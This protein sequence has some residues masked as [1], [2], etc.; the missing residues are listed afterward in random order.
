MK[1]P[2]INVHILIIK[3]DK[4]LLGLLT[5][6]CKYKGKQAYGIPGCDI[7][8]DEKIRGYSQEKY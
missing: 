8:L 4:I 1:S 3:N 6:K 2:G 5:K 7:K